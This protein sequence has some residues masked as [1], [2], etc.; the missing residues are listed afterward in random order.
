MKFASF[1]LAV[2]V[3]MLSVAPCC[4]NNCCIDDKTE[5]KAAPQDNNCKG[6]CSPFFACGSCSGFSINF[7][8]AEI[9]KPLL[10]PATQRLVF[11]VD[12]LPTIS[13]PVWQP[14]QL[15]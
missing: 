14:P 10:Q 12:Q 11:R 9:K 6:N 3:L 7:T 8:F 1:V 13:L 5:Q 15:S 4:K 2:M